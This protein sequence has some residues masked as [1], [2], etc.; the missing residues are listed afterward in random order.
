MNIKKT[1][2]DTITRREILAAGAAAGLTAGLPPLALA[3]APSRPNI[4]WIMADDMGFADTG[5][6][7]LR[8][9]RTP[10]IDRIAHE[11]LFLRQ[12][13]SNSA[14]C[15]ATRVG[16]I[17]GR[18]QY[19][20]DVGLQEP[21]ANGNDTG[22]P[23]S[24]PTLPSLLR[25]AGYRTALVGKWHMGEGEKYGPLLSGYERFYGFLKGAAD[26][27]RHDAANLVD[28]VGSGLLDGNQPVWMANDIACL[29]LKIQPK[30]F[31]LGRR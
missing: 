22:L 2:P 30:V 24:H 18:Y 27:F 13:Y 1:T 12:S 28:G 8:D 21:L 4:I 9:L 19:R 6:T 20:L 17:T 23:P 3:A 25:K 14:V 5:V 7:G 16:L 10:N 31:V 29:I 11:G 26:Y 15:T